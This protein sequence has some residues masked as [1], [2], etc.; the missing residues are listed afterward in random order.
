M[1]MHTKAPP[2]GIHKSGGAAALS[3]ACSMG[4]TGS[5]LQAA[6]AAHEHTQA[7]IRQLAGLLRHMSV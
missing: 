4:N 6:C 3:W 2:L 5:R 7:Q 1:Q